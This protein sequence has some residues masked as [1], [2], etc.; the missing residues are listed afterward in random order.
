MTLPKYLSKMLSSERVH[1]A[2]TLLETKTKSLR[3]T[4]S[5]S[6][7]WCLG[8]GIPVGELVMFWGPP[9][10]GK[11]LFSLKLI[12]EEQRKH[13]NKYALWIDTEYSFD[14]ERARQLGVDID[15][16]VIIQSNTFEGAIAPLAKIE[17]EIQENKD[18]CA[19]V[20]DS[21]KALTSINEQ[22]QMEE[23]N[24]QSAAN[25]YG[26]IAKSVNPAVNILN[27]LANECGILTIICNH[28]MMNMDPM[29]AKYEPYTLTGGQKVKHLCS[30]TV[31]LNKVMSKDSKIFSQMK[32][33]QGKEIVIGNL[34][35][36]KVNKTRRTVEGK[37]AE[38]F[39]NMETGE[40]EKKELE[41]ARLAEG[42]GVLYKPEGQGFYYYGEQERGIRAR[43]IDAFA[44]LFVSDKNLYAKVLQSVNS[45]KWVTEPIDKADVIDME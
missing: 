25:A 18:C 38:F 12:A 39:I 1:V 16:L 4:G 21:L 7:D 2:K 15:R 20:L 6:L 44:D 3:S 8:G 23:G 17:G 33:A 43:T 24:V 28:A 9:G 41:L 26:G 32:D 29:T 14:S 37:V 10:C 11:T 45:I 30:T 36:C 42:L 22:E 27:R 5:V 13:P 34:I 19:I 35:R 40:L 31:F